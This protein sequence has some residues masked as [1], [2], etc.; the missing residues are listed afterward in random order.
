MATIEQKVTDILK[1]RFND[2]EIRFDHESGERISG[3]MISEEFTDMDHEARHEAVWTPLRSQLT[4]E[5]R[6]QVLGFLVYTPKEIETYS[7][8]YEDKI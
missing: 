3:F 8:T 6:L 5:E 4:K 1:A 7:E 2:I